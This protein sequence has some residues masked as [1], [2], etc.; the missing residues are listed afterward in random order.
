VGWFAEASELACLLSLQ[1][2]CA[3]HRRFASSLQALEVS[4]GDGARAQ[5]YGEV[6]RRGHGIGDGVVH[7]SGASG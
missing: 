1:C 4:D 7:P 6:I 5:R 2:L 3:A